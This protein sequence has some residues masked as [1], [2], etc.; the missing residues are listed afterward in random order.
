MSKYHSTPK[1]CWLSWIPGHPW[2]CESIPQKLQSNTPK[3]LSVG[4]GPSPCWWGPLIPCLPNTRSLWS[5]GSS[6]PLSLAVLNCSTR[7]WVW[8]VSRKIQFTRFE[9]EAHTSTFS[10]KY[11]GPGNSSGLQEVALSLQELLIKLGKRR[12]DGSTRWWAMKQKLITSARLYSGHEHDT[13]AGS[14]V[15]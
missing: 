1:D 14:H 5:A 7:A 2:L 3:M 4:L 12:S 15:C 9:W 6:P 11:T 8:N 13:V 10:V